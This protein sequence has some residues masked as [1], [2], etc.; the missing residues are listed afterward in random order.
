MK[1][2][3]L[4]FLLAAVMVFGMVFASAGEAQAASNLKTSEACIALIK[5]L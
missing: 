3:W 5:Q 1:K 2:R 4:S